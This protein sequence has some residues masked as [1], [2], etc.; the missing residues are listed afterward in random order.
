MITV[1]RIERH[2]EAR[3]FDKLFLETT[4]ARPEAVLR[5]GIDTSRPLPAAAM[6]IMRLDELGQSHA[7]LYPTL[8]KTII[9]AQEADGGWGDLITTA[10]CLRALF[11]GAGNGLAIQR[12]L[13]YLAA[14]Q[15]SEGIWPN[16]PIR[17]MPADPYL[18]ALILY[19]LGDRPMFHQTVRVADAARWFTRNE[20]WVDAETRE[21]WRRSVTRFRLQPAESA[22]RSWQ[23]SSDQ[24]LSA[25]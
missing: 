19:L 25:P 12:G 15:K 8:V 3:T 21:L 6:A 7:K 10:L 22:S 1:R 9:G 13:A 5:L 4:T 18:S 2:W 14:L 11:C 17:R 16:V 23:F 24:I 20:Q